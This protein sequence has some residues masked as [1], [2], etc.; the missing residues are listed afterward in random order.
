[1]TTVQ[2][3]AAGGLPGFD[4]MGPWKSP[5]M[6]CLALCILGGV[7]RLIFGKGSCVVLSVSACTQV[8]LV[9][10]CA[11]CLY[12][13][14]PS[15]RIAMPVLPFLDLRP[16]CLSLID[17]PSMSAQNFFPSLLQL[18]ILV[19]FVN[20]LEDILPRGQRLFSWILLRFLRVCCSLGMY[21][22]VCALVSR[23]APEIFGI[24][25]GWILITIWLLIGLLGLSKGLLTLIA[26]VIN[27]VL[28]LLFAFFFTNLF[29]K[30]MS[31]SILTCLLSVI[32]FSVLNEAGFSVFPISGISL[33][34]LGPCLLMIFTVLYTFRMFL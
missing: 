17:I 7:L 4:W 14:I 33:P 18:Y 24:W 20:L 16:D 29:G 6:L 25:S 31:K 12:A 1:M 13:Q 34:V 15:V 32:I 27:P 3:M 22:G 21:M 10:L 2:S 30:Q 28:G 23:F 26:A 5:L 8:A 11:A 9:Y 19:L